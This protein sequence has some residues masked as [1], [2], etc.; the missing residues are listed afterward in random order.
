MLSA[1]K[2]AGGNSAEYY[3]ADNYYEAGDN[4][5]GSEWLG[6]GAKHAGLTGAIDP[7]VFNDARDGT[8][9]DGSTAAQNT[10]NRVPGWDFTFSAPKSISLLALVG[11]DDRLIEAHRAAS[12]TAMS[13][14]E[15]H[16]ATR[17]RVGQSTVKRE[18]TGNL[19]VGR[20]T[21]DTSRAGDPAL[22]DHMYVTNR[23]WHAATQSW[24]ALDSR[25]IYA[26][27]EATGR[28][29]SA[30]LREN[31]RAL[32]YGV[33]APNEAGS[34][35]VK[36][37]NDDLIRQFSKRR[38]T[39]LET[40]KHTVQGATR[41]VRERVALMTR[42]RKDIAG[43]G[44][45][46][47]EEWRREAGTGTN[48]LDTLV[49]RSK[50]FLAK[51][52]QHIARAASHL[53]AQAEVISSA[54]GAHSNAQ[55]AGSRS[56]AAASQAVNTGLRDVTAQRAVFHEADL[57]AA[58]L[59]TP[60]AKDAEVSKIIGLID[61][62][63]SAGRLSYAEAETPS[64]M[65][66]ADALRAEAK[67]VARIQDLAPTW[68]SGADLP[69]D[70]SAKRA[71]LQTQQIDMFRSILDDT[72]RYKTVSGVAGSGKS[73]TLETVQKTL[74]KHRP[75][76]K[77]EVLA[78]LNEQVADLRKTG[79]DARTADSFA[80]SLRHHLQP[81]T[82][83]EPEDRSNRIL[84]IDEAGQLPTKLMSSIMDIAQKLNY[85]RVVFL[86]DPRQHGAIDAGAPFITALEAGR[87]DVRLTAIERQKDPRHQSAAQLASRGLVGRALDVLGPNL[88]TA[89]E[90]GIEASVFQAWRS[91]PDNK[92]EGALIVLTN[93]ER[94][95]KT[96]TM[97]RD[98]LIND[99]KL[100]AVQR[101]GK[102][103][104]DAERLAQRQNTA[105]R[106]NAGI[107]LRTSDTLIFNR[108][109]RAI[110][111][112]KGDAVTLVGL[113]SK[114]RTA[115]LEKADGGRVPYKLPGNKHS[116]AHFR[117]YERKA[118]ELREGEKLR[119][120]RTDKPRGF[121]AG[122][123][124]KLARLEENHVTLTQADGKEVRLEK[125]DPQLKHIDYGY[126]QT[127]YAA[128][129]KTNDTVIGGV[130][131][132]DKR[133]GSHQSLYVLLSR[134]GSKAAGDWE[135]LQIVTNDRDQ[136]IKRLSGEW[137]KAD[138]ATLQS[139]KD[140]FEKQKHN[141]SID[142]F[143]GGARKPAGRMDLEAGSPGP[144]RSPSQTETPLQERKP[145][146]RPRT[147][148]RGR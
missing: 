94:R 25:S 36:G 128:Q 112:E 19:L 90:K 86:G 138:S 93:N 73:Y 126:A 111:I 145:Q 37:V 119:W 1:S 121:N 116:D 62:E 12:K 125:A 76:A 13:Y 10:P 53:P 108:N 136:L 2:D 18:R 129:G 31:V 64:H 147:P 96:V 120:T 98:A 58:A 141:K 42:E 61:K 55:R 59:Q 5:G 124:F 56:F 51:A 9:P 134:V 144:S 69:L 43:T 14:M 7:K 95:A 105:A 23:T 83:A 115:Q 97:I 101:L 132:E 130:G 29:Y 122:N 103:R 77:L 49:D 33:T 135:K 81:D 15:R 123:H 79:L 133:S 67:L 28:I 32:G 60:S 17:V 8:L 46:K 38:E 22:H 118:I 78:P 27:K 4:P 39:I 99:A 47:A 140:A 40:L 148:D 131:A 65:T 109:L 75:E 87:T 48:Q 30:A 137:A 66:T 63:R 68:R 84:A 106:S 52:H 54:H 74:A 100:P 92:R 113:D 34:F 21:H 102:K 91:L 6:E 26:A 11:K 70:D 88:S 41:G 110:G 127:S 45:A 89:G 80:Q 104:Y 16:A 44:S 3:A 85:G 71:G 143:V 146:E 114:T 139:V 20:Y 107:G 117:I 35:E 142:E 82:K 50:S 57:V 24:R 72:N